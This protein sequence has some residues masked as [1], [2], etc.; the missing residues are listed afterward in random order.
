MNQLITK[1]KNEKN[2]QIKISDTIK[3]YFKI[4][5]FFQNVSLAKDRYNI[6][7]DFKNLIFL[8]YY[9]RQ[10]AKKKLTIFRFYQQRKVFKRS[11]N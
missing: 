7:L 5:N 9:N 1:N 4:I 2:E 8:Y 10:F 3:L 6:K 11:T